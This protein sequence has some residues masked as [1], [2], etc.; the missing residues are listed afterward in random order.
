M[1]LPA[2]AALLLGSSAQ[3][4]HKPLSSH[5]LRQGHTWQQ[6]TW[7]TQSAALRTTGELRA[8]V[9]RGHVSPRVF[10]DLPK[11]IRR[12]NVVEPEGQ[13]GM[14]S[15]S[16]ENEFQTNTV[17]G[18]GEIFRPHDIPEAA[19]AAMSPRQREEISQVHEGKNFV[20]RDPYDDFLTTDAWAYY[21]Q[22]YKFQGKGV[23]TLEELE[24][25]VRLEER[26]GLNG[27]RQ[28]WVVC[29]DC[30]SFIRAN[31]KG[32]AGYFRFAADLAEF[33]TLVRGH[34]RHAE[35]SDFLPGANFFHGH[36]Q[37]AT[38]EAG[39]LV[40]KELDQYDGRWKESRWSWLGDDK[41]TK[42]IYGSA[43]RRL[44]DQDLAF[45]IRS[46]NRSADSLLRSVRMLT[47]AMENGFSTY[48]AY[49]T[50]PLTN[51]D[52]IDLTQIPEYKYGV[53]ERLVGNIPRGGLMLAW[54][55]RDWSSHPILLELPA[56]ERERA[57]QKIAQ[58]TQKLAFVL[59]SDE[60]PMETIRVA[61]ARWA[62]ES[63]L[64]Q[65]FVAAM[66]Q[67]VRQAYEREVLAR[68]YPRLQ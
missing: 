2:L 59:E 62:Y 57:K 48:E 58:A 21:G 27:S 45:E 40:R 43:L 13:A 30:D 9:L 16:L 36:N 1:R 17:R 44:G 63:E 23:A 53:I 60:T 19:W 54:A 33:E 41:S 37:V 15:F 18:Y 50:A 14:I 32:I 39:E 56:E 51:E 28:A 46:A 34:R 26:V 10:A 35:Q 20:V 11:R 55:L 8:A 42:F 31:K 12:T 66:P 6:S 61:V 22:E 67:E 29:N 47:H 49:A 4:N 25:W 7:R 24:A 65:H 68:D 64:L 52:R 5:V 38:E 3:A